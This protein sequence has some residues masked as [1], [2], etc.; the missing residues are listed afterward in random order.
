[1][2]QAESKSAIKI[3]SRRL[4]TKRYSVERIFF[5]AFERFDRIES[6]ERISC[7]K[8]DGRPTASTEKHL[9]IEGVVFCTGYIYRFYR[10]NQESENAGK[11]K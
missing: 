10:K 9:H 5:S 1:M 11:K 3:A 8:H 2:C 4:E 6:I 7:S